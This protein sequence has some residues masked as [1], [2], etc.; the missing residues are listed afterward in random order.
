MDDARRPASYVAPR[1]RD[2]GDLLSLTAD[3]G[4]LMHI[5][6]GGTSVLAAASAPVAPGGGG[7]SVLGAHATGSGAVL[8]AHGVNPVPHAG[9]GGEAGA[10]ES[11]AGTGGGG[12]GAG[13]GHG[14]GGHGGGELPFTGFAAALV[15]A[16]GSGL[17]A[18]GVA[19]RRALRRRES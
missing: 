19:I 10:L 7:G 16:L 9:T 3:G 15:G 13:A 14:G 18:S 2:Y 5:G 6:I 8:G 1:I 4:A 11:P 12:G 17:A